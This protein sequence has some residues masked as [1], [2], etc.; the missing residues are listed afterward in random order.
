MIRTLMTRF[1][2]WRRARAH[3]AR[4]GSG[5]PQATTGRGLQGPQSPDDEWARGFDLWAASRKRGKHPRRPRLGD[6]F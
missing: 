4:Y 5:L 3:R 6:G 1:Q 2:D